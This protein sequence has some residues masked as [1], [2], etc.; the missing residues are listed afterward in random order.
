MVFR[1]GLLESGLGVL[2]VL[3]TPAWAVQP[4]VPESSVA[5]V[6]APSR[7]QPGGYV[8]G[9]AFFVNGSQLVTNE[10]VVS[11]A[12]SPTALSIVREGRS[13]LEPVRLVWADRNLDLAVV[14]WSGFGS[15]EAL[16]ISRVEPV[17]GAAVFAIGYPG[18]AD[19][20]S[21]RSAATSST[22]TEGIVSRRP[23]RAH[24][25]ASNVSL[26]TVIQH[27]APTNP[28]N[29]GGPLVDACGAVVG[30]NTAGGVGEVH[31]EAGNV[32]GST[33]APGIYFALAVS[34]L[35]PQLRRL[36][37]NFR[38]AGECEPDAPRRVAPE[39]DPPEPDPGR[40]S[41]SRPQ[42]E[43]R[44]PPV[45]RPDPDP[46]PMPIPDPGGGPGSAGGGGSRSTPSNS[47]L[48]V[49]LLLLAGLLAVVLIRTRA[50]RRGAVPP[51][52]P[53]GPGTPGP[54]PSPNASPRPEATPR[55][56]ATQPPPPAPSPPGPRGRT[57]RLAGVAGSADLRFDGAALRSARLGLSVGR[58]PALVDRSVADPRLSR[59]HFRLARIGGRDFVE[60][61]HSANG[62]WVGSARLKPYHAR[63]LETGDVI[64]AGSGRWRYDGA[65]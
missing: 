53:S 21:V 38:T 8:T 24:W 11:G 57:T 18:A 43:T 27:T 3:A 56:I 12:I 17:R 45:T 23:F 47:W 63:R 41:S 7:E 33:N 26:A 65:R 48:W 62:T 31:D 49:L 6:V 19:L 59:R 16:T 29:S 13:A 2:V 37:V 58:N 55:P 39:P 4:P 20:V 30:V 10:H 34:E 51:L 22:L 28:G 32:I 60:D 5:R 25:G 15:P 40:D 42:P 52:P 54:S 36:G 1:R 44:T 64:R 35:V 61:L 50:S 46:P 9:S 14:A